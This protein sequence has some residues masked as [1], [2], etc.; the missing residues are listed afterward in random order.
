MNDISKLIKN[1]ILFKDRDYLEDSLKNYLNINKKN[2]LKSSENIDFIEEHIKTLPIDYFYSNV[3][4]R[5]SKTMT[6]CRNLRLNFKN[7]GTEG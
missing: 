5:A 3:I 2:N 1:K 4:A 7:T 6:E